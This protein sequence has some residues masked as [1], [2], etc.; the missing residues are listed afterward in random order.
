MR[1][2]WSGR[3]GRRRGLLRCWPL[4]RRRCRSR[5][6]SGCTGWR[7]GAWRESGRWQSWR[8]WMCCWA[9]A[10]P[11]RR[12]MWRRGPGWRWAMWPRWRVT[13][14]PSRTIPSSGRRC[15][16]AMR[17]GLPSAA[18]GRSSAISAP[19]IWPRAGRA[20]RWHPFFTTR[21]W[22]MRARGGWC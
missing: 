19:A 10:L 8:R 3:R 16:L 2:W 9:S 11:R 22:P 15:R 21:R 17:R 5:C 13:G 12:G 1:R 20:R 14:R 6:R 4:R 7:R 18:G